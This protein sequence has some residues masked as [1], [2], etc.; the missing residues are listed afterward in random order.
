MFELLLLLVQWG[1]TDWVKA[2]LQSHERFLSGPECLDSPFQAAKI[3][4]SDEKEG[5][6]KKF[7]E[8]DR[9][10]VVT[11]LER[12]VQTGRSSN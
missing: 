4:L 6:V 5:R 10:V 12:L 1:L 2:M 9:E 7:L 11:F 3:E 8:S